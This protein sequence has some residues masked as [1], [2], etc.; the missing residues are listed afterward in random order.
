MVEAP[1]VGVERLRVSQE[2]LPVQLPRM[3]ARLPDLLALVF[4]AK[5]MPE[6]I[7]S[8]AD[9]A[10]LMLHHLTPQGEFSRQRIGLALPA[11]MRGSKNQWTA[12][13]GSKS[14]P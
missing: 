3:M 10:A 4:F 11:G 12:Q 1:P 9:A 13:A 7:V 8:Y 2:H 14:K 6:M 5:R